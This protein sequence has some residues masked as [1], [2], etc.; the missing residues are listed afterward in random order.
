MNT[1]DSKATV[2]LSAQYKLSTTLILTQRIALI[3]VT[4]IK[5]LEIKFINL[6]PGVSFLI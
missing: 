3:G 1:A 4:V 6:L 2:T 5:L